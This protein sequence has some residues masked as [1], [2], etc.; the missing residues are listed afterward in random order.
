MGFLVYNPLP[1]VDL[2]TERWQEVQ[3]SA[4]DLSQV[5]ASENSRNCT[6]AP[7]SPSSA[8]EELVVDGCLRRESHFS[9]KVDYW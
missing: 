6:G 9:L 5:Q 3:L 2:A 4:E 8:E 7:K 1:Q